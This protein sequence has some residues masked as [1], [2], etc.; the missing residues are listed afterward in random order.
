MKK[1]ILAVPFLLLI[2]LVANAQADG[3]KTFENWCE[4]C[5]AQSHNMPGTAHIEELFGESRKDLRN[6]PFVNA[7]TVRQI[8][9]NGR[10]MMPPF[11]RTE[12]SN[13]ALDELIEYLV[14]E[15]QK[16]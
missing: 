10:G 15:N 5:H 3:A 2:G 8:V 11:R 9:R 6:S 16:Q 7:A 4:I 13:A 12:I 14:A 1:S